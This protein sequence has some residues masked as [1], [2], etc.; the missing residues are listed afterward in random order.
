MI[1]MTQK[2][3]LLSD[4]HGNMTALEAVVAD[5]KALGVSDY[6][7]LG[8]NILPGPGNMELF[9]LLESLQS[10]VSIRGNWDDSY[11]EAIDGEYDLSHPTHIYL[12]KLSQYLKNKLSQS[13]IDYI[14]SLPN[15]VTRELNGLSFSISHNLPDKNWGGEL[16]H[17]AKQENIDRLV[18]N[19]KCD[20]AIYGHI[21][22]QTLRYA[23]NGQLIINPGSI[24][25]PYYIL[26]NLKK[27]NRAHYAILEIDD[28]G[29][30][31]VF[32]KIP[33]DVEKELYRAKEKNLPFFELYKKQLLLGINSTHDTD[34]LQTIIDKESYLTQVSDF[35]AQISK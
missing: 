25:N 1:T 12:L 11:L 20:V 14:R 4:I 35:L 27:D 23:S 7:L 8:D 18:T 34:A 24:G 19:N 17:N 26:E 29:I 28:Y 13:V 6:W 10:T 31:P 15:Y 21:H 32:R 16:V 5:A 33:Y 9:D 30:T 22:M 3:A 2:I